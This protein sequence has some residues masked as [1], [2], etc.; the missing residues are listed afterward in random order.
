MWPDNETDIDLLGF[1]F[2][3]DELEVLLTEE[4]LLPLTVG[5][6]GDWGSGK[7]SLMG[8][9]R[10]RL[11]SGAN[12]GKFIC[13]SFSPWRFEDFGYARVALMAAVI[14]A[15]EAYAADKSGSDFVEVGKKARRLGRFVRRLG[16]ARYLGTAGALAS[17]LGPQEAALLGTAA[18]AAT[19]GADKDENGEND[20]DGVPETVFE[21]VA[22]FHAVFEELVKALGDDVQAVVVFIDDMD[23][24]ST[25]TIV[26]TFE[27]MRLFVHAD[28]TAYVIGAHEEIVE[29]ALEGRYPARQEGDEHLGRNYLEKMLQNTVAVPHL[30]HPEA[31]TYINLLFTELFTDEE[32]FER[33]RHVTAENRHANPFAV[34][35][36]ETIATETIGELDAELVEGLS[37]AEQVGSPLAR[38][39]RG[40]PRQLKRFLNRLRLRRAAAAKRKLTLDARA[41]AKLMVLEEL[42][43][44]HFERLF[45]W[46]M[47]T[48]T[49][50]PSEVG[51]AERLANGEAVKDAPSEVI[52]WVAQ[53][54]VRDWLLLQPTLAGISLGPYYTFSRDRLTTTISGAR[55][56]AEL[57][58]LL[59]DL[60][61]DTD[62]KRTAAVNK[63]AGLEAEP[64]SQLL[65]SLVESARED[66]GS[67]GAKAL[68]ELATK[69]SE[70]ATALFD[71][72]EKL[73][74]RKVKGN[75]VLALGAAFRTDPRFAPLAQK[76]AE[77]GTKAVQT[78]A[79]RVL[80]PPK[81]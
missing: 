14:D 31:L 65:P 50:A 62:P 7:S 13:V 12:E 28:K 4:R 39:L 76:W 17:G 51:I 49:G 33:L 57:Q 20:E 59:G 11:E 3:V 37:I 6:S 70:A 5:V 15:I 53:P 77:K 2:L 10:A 27:A 80:K 22:E 43:P 67:D 19:A 81:A 25:A 35:M 66:V 40:N 58:Q 63:A 38:G 71:M 48:D 45:V 29:A 26:E 36:N 34:A 56:P 9:T 32:Q 44:K 30:S 55:L 75:F 18:D 79:E 52:D 78:Q 60:H 24:C 74:P 23:R 72:L 73:P 64:M 41:L 47:E 42:Y 1:D 16:L 21:T 8:M 61:S 46:Q 68:I 54:G 69:R